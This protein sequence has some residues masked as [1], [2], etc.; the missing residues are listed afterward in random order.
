MLLPALEK[1]DSE[2][3]SGLYFMAADYYGLAGQRDSAEWYYR[4]LLDKGN[5]YTQQA[6]HRALADISMTKSGSTETALKHLKQYEALTDSVISLNDNEA[7]RRYNALYNYQLHER[8]TQRLQAENQRVRLYIALA[9]IAIVA[10][11]LALI[12][13]QLY[14][15][16]RQLAYRLR[17]EQLEQ[18]LARQ[19]SLGTDEAAA[20]HNLVRQNPVYTAI[21]QTIEEQEEPIPLKAEQWKALEQAVN[22]VY[23]NFTDRL[24]SF[25]R[26]SSFEYHVCLLLKTDIAPKYIAYLTAHSKQSVTTA[27]SRLYQKAFGQKGSAHDWDE[28]ID[29]L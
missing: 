18:L 27:R 15:G 2:N 12:V 29:S 20:K 23:P 9:A 19:K 3:V 6:A 14:F 21:V 1:A 10:L 25:C 26:P 11:V 5:I 4:Q 7:M 28:V 13:R 17:I 8:E 24:Y 16:R 22:E